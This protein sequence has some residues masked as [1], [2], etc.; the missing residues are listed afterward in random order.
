M[1]I[2][3]KKIIDRKTG[4]IGTVLSVSYKFVKDR[5]MIQVRVEFEYDGDYI[6]LNRDINN[7]SF[8]GDET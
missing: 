7:V 1:S 2:I 4:D 3:G 6:T 8:L 5:F